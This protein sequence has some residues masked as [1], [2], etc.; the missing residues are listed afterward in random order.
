MRPGSICAYQSS[1]GAP[2]S[3]IPPRWTDVGGN[4]AEAIQC[5]SEVGVGDRGRWRQARCH[6][7]G[8]WRD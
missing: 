8:S 6:T 7:S 2:I 3:E 5:Y 4:G 1:P